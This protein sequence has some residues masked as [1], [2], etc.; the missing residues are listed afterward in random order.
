MIENE[1]DKIMDIAQKEDYNISRERAFDILMCSIYCYKSLDYKLNW[2][3]LINENITDGKNDGGIDFVF[4]DDENSKVIIGQNKYSKNIKV[5]DVIAEVN[6]INS[7]LYNFE[8]ESTSSY[9]RVVKKLLRN[10]LDSLPEEEE[11][12]IEIVFSSTSQVKEKEVIN[13]VNNIQNA[14]FGD[15]NLLNELEIDK[16]IEEM[17]QTLEVAKEFKFEIDK[18]KNALEY[19]S[20]NYEG[21]VVNVSANSLKVAYEKFERDGLFNMNIRRY[22]KSKNVDDPIIH[23]MRKNPEDFWVMNNGI[24]IACND[25]RLDGDNVKVYDFSIVNGGQTTHLIA[26][27]IDSSKEDFYLMCKIIKKNNS[28]VDEKSFFNSI[29]EATNSQKA[30]Q[31]KDLKANAPEMVLLQRILKEEGIFLEIKRGINTP[32]KYGANKIKNEEFAQI[33]YSFVYQK[34]GTARS[35]KRSLFA[36]NNHYKSIFKLDYAADKNKVKF[37]KDLIDLNKRIGYIIQDIKDKKQE[38]EIFDNEHMIILN[39]GRY[40]LIAIIGLI[41]RI[42]NNDP[43]SKNKQ[44]LVGDDFVFGEFLSNYKEDDLDDKLKDLIIE[45]VI[46]LKEI[47]DDEYALSN[48]TSPSNFFKTD[49]KYIDKIAY[50]IINKTR[51][52]RNYED[53]INAYGDVFKRGES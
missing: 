30:I 44:D 22:I 28:K 12:N 15:F 29:A 6:K 14:K 17:K 16:V 13:K 24:T 48:V 2:Y 21:L 39:N 50:K 8:K 42:A 10:S 5:N 51:V 33:F 18:S 31:P 26:K 37:I 53:L 25:Y 41:Y 20:D 32:R 27:N 38:N 19:E 47:Y 49:K 4:Y 46:L 40:A 45:Y 43:G 9:S 23:S 36:N 3:D 7:T 52:K 11:G 34:P 35:A 1:L